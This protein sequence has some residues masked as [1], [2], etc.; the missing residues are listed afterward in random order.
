MAIASWGEPDQVLFLSI[1]A[2]E[3]QEDAWDAIT[4]AAAEAGGGL[5]H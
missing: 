3:A 5:V 4:R 2:G 1:H